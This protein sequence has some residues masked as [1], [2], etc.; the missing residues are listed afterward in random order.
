MG[1]CNSHVRKMMPSL[2]MVVLCIASTVA[3]PVVKP[4]VVD[5]VQSLAKGSRNL[6][7]DTAAVT[8][9]VTDK[10]KETDEK[11]DKSKKELEQAQSEKEKDLSKL[12]DEVKN[13]NAK[14]QEVSD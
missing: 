9:A 10:L 11:V 5:N 6:A 13:K 7:D 4:D 3:V 8:Q 12:T 1:S 2:L 14:I